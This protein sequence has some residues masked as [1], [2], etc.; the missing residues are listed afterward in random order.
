MGNKAGSKVDKRRRFNACPANRYVLCE[1]R[2]L[3]AS[4]A[5][6]NSGVVNRCLSI[7]A[8]LSSIPL[9]IV[10]IKVSLSILMHGLAPPET[11]ATDSE[12]KAN[13]PQL[14]SSRRTDFHISDFLNYFCD[15]PRTLSYQYPY[16]QLSNAKRHRHG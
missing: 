5:A 11:T 12:G 13:P 1:W 3:I 16:A 9:Y 14:L 6:G 7:S 4:L 8:V 2:G 15:S 10:N